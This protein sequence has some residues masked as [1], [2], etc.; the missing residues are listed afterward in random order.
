MRSLPRP[1]KLVLLLAV[2]V[3]IAGAATGSIARLTS[4]DLMIT[5]QFESAA[6]VF[7]GN[8]VAVLGMPVGKVVSVEQRGAY[9]EVRI[10]VDSS[11]RIPATVTAV[12]V[13]DSVL[14]DRHI[15]FTP[16][17]RS[18]PVLADGA[19]LGPDRTR[20]PVEFD[21]LLAMAD[22]LS[23]SLAG[24]GQGHGPI[25]DM[26]EVGAAVAG[27]NGND[28]KSALDQ[29][30]RAL[31]M[32]DDHG[33][34][35]RDAITTLVNNL[36]A[37]TTAAANNDQKIREFGQGVRQLSDLLAD[38][39][40]GEGDTG[41][42][43][44]EIL[45]RTT[46]LMQQSRGEL[47]GTVSGGNVVIKSLADYRREVAEFMDVFPLAVNNAYAVV[48]QEAGAARVHV[49]IDKVALDGQMVK[50]ICNLLDLK[51]LG[52]NTGKMSD[53]GPDFGIV[54]MLV[55]IAGLPK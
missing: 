8:S 54:A 25:G 20:T 44:N 43:L 21:S 5:A 42:K 9:A 4:E 3:A 47:A 26:V 52:C 33:A 36:D 46:D 28:I 32:G 49:N 13:S 41:A 38:Q 11:V 7:P 40:L 48:D 39:R 45:I 6:G 55:G 12:I 30:S 23:T 51:Q 17:Y 31:R 24:D 10:S 34:A 15:E 22:K 27:S 2:V 37:L 53:M 1:V 18:G 29:L 14:T 19:V 35:T 16:V 50:Q